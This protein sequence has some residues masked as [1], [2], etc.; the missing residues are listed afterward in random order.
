VLFA[1]KTWVGYATEEKNLPGLRKG[2][3]SCNAVPLSIKQPLP[4]ESL[5][6]VDYWYA[7]DYEPL[8]DLRLI[9]KTY[10]QLGS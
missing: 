1:K 9:W 6:M 4:A 5:R 2:I 10:K 3:I 8:H 7:R